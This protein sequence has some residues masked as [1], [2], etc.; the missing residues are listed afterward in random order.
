[1][2]PRQFEHVGFTLPNV[3]LSD[4]PEI[5]SLVAMGPLLEMLCALG[6]VASN[7]DF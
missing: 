5:A 4:L 2:K 1:M 7:W 6:E 3:H